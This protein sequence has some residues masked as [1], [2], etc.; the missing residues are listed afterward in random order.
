MGLFDKIKRSAGQQTPAGAQPDRAPAQPNQ[1]KAYDKYGRELMIPAEKWRNEVLP[2][3]ISRDWN[4]SAALY[5]TIVLAAQDGFHADVL[6]ASRRMHALAPADEGV[7]CLHGI[8]L[9]KNGLADEA[10]KLFRDYLGSRPGSAYVLCN[11]AKVVDAHGDHA[12]AEA[13][14]WQSLTIDP[15]QDNGLLWWGATHSDRTGQAG[16]LQ[17]MEKVAV[18]PGSWRAQLWLA[19]KALEGKDLET[20]LGYYRTV[21]DRA[22]DEPD[23]LMMISGDLG[24]SGY[25][26][27]IVHVLAPIY[28]VEKHG[29]LAGL[30]LLQAYL[31]T[32][33]LAGAKRLLHELFELNRPDLR[34]H[35][36]RFSQECD[37]LKDELE[38]MKQEQAPPA[39][40][41]AIL[42][43]PVWFPDLENPG[44]LLPKKRDA[45]RILFLTLA[46]TSRS[47]VKE[48]M[49]QK[50]DDIGR[51]TRSIPLYLAEAFLFETGFIAASAL[52]LVN[53]R[54]PVVSGADWSKDHVLQ[55]ARSQDRKINYVVT[56]SMAEEAGEYTVSFHV[57]NIAAEAETA[58][59]S[60]TGGKSRI[61]RIMAALQGDLLQFFRQPSAK[62]S[63][64]GQRF[65]YA[66]GADL[67]DEYLTAIGQS[68]TLLLARRAGNG[69]ELWGERALLGIPLG[70]SLK[71]PD[72][73]IPK[74]MFLAGLIRNKGYGSEI[75][76]E[77][78]PPL[79][80]LLEDGPSDSALV[81]L[82]PLVHRLF[83]DPE[84]FLLCKERLQKSA[85][86]DYAAW[87]DHLSF[88]SPDRD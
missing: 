9:S 59:F 56:G 38:P 36:I 82:A 15:N 2:G 39:I 45:E 66:P 12:E 41:W 14:L 51:L 22:P 75:Y 85:S 33:D 20:A 64:G 83:D 47:T 10:E 18:L 54:Y 17:A 79:T 57:W 74:L 87:L 40:E 3:Q 70:L 71:M 43:T 31:A 63:A 46:N 42:A 16:F 78:K 80:A 27:Q 72:A 28:A 29:P 69:D 13:L 48:A 44:W 62:L 19:R 11:L 86:G 8:V 52:P 84:E 73:P 25:V 55:L 49:K 24:N 88:T 5:R 65:Y 77:F 7:V 23:A 67:M 34:E 37:K 30:N 50:T 81:R 1:I 35:L 32:K 76:R 68:L 4:D 61:G 60:Q 6:A 53:G 26:E 58:S 21:L